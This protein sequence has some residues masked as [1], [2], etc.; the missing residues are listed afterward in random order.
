MRAGAVS[1]LS[2][3]EDTAFVTLRV[4]YAIVAQL[5]LSLKGRVLQPRR[6]NIKNCCGL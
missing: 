5:C 6:E 1:G 4:Y 3:N 2:S